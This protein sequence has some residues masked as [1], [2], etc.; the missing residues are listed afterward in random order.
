MEKDKDERF[1][2][3]CLLDRLAVSTKLQYEERARKVAQETGLPI[4]YEALLRFFRLNTR[5]AP[6][7]LRGFKSAVVTILFANG[8]PMSQDDAFKLDRVLEG[9]ECSKA[10]TPRVR[11]APSEDQVSE[12]ARRAREDDHVLE[13]KAIFVGF[14]IACRTRELADMEAC[15]IDLE[16]GFIQVETKA[17]RF[18]K[19]RRPFT[20]K[21]ITCPTAMKILKVQSEKFPTGKIFPN[22]DTDYINRLIRTVASE[23]GWDPDLLW[24]GIHN[25]RHGK[26]AEVMQKAIEEVRRSALK[27]IGEKVNRK[28]I[29]KA[30]SASSTFVSLKKDLAL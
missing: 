8:S 17:P 11:A 5:L 22:L 24:T 16:K 21:P 19:I 28:Q 6:S 27:S 4:G 9:L 3:Q 7:T 12:V 20:E 1:A 13:A 10:Q 23:Q 26:A 2:T 29:R 30:P 25:L 15:H 14:G 18:T